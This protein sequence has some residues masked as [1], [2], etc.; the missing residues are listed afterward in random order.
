MKCN[1]QSDRS[2]N[3]VSHERRIVFSSSL[4][5]L[6]SRKISF[7]DSRKCRDSRRTYS[8]PPL[9]FFE[10]TLFETTVKAVSSVLPAE[11]RRRRPERSTRPAETCAGADRKLSSFFAAYSCQ[12]RSAS[13]ILRRAISSG[14]K[15]ILWSGSF[16]SCFLTIS[17]SA[18]RSA[19]SFSSAVVRHIGW[20]LRRAESQ[21]RR[22]EFLFV[23]PRAD[24]VVSSSDPSFAKSA[25]VLTSLCRSNM[26]TTQCRNKKKLMTQE[27]G[28]IGSGRRVHIRTDANVATQPT[29]WVVFQDRG[30]LV[31]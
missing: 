25:C 20:P 10:P 18:L 8:R 13:A 19:F 3:S 29:H 2:S 27:W 12:T 14:D 31:R 22:I 4:M 17:S 21:K 26:K 5:F 28:S 9:Q 11:L 30:R 16:S 15:C 6:L 7:N 23:P 24:R 1:V